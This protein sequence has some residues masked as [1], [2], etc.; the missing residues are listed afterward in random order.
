M[1]VL[2]AGAT[3]AVGRHL[4]P[5]L[6]ARGHRVTALTRRADRVPAL[7][8]A[9]ADAVVADALDRPA[10]LAAVAA[11]RPA[12]VLHQL[13][14]LSAGDLAANARIRREG[15]RNLVDAA[16]AV[17]VTRIVAQSIS[18]VYQPGD[19][20]ADEQ[21]PLDGAAPEPR[22][23]TV[24]GVRALESAVRELP[25]AVVLRYG[26]FY[27]PGTMTA[28]D[29]VRAE[30][31]R[32]GSLPADGN[33]TSFVHVADAAA[34]AVEALSWAPGVLNVCDD[35]PAAGAEWV[36]AFC[37]AVGAPVPPAADGREGWARG[38]DNALLHK[39]GFALRYPSWREGFASL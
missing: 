35:E 28:A 38:A 3:G 13:T 8:S 32:A 18:W 37:R 1:N 23:T 24:E 6:I 10:L 36:P 15:T 29:G 7:R 27:G 4:L 25:E 39:A 17:G 5:M 26:A 33:V 16:R 14:D 2:V 21:T 20:P 22:R 12:A 30:Q 9:G 31:A 19:G 34:A 11:A